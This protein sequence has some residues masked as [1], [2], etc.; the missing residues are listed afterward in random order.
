VTLFSNISVTS[1][2]KLLVEDLGLIFNMIKNL[3]IL[4][5]SIV[6]FEL[7]LRFSLLSGGQASA[8]YDEKI[9]YWHK[10]NFTSQ[11][12]RDCYNVEYKFGEYGEISPQQPYNDE[13]PNI[14]LLGNSYLEAA[15]V[16]NENIIHNSLYKKLNGKYNVL[17]FGLYGSNIFNQ[18]LI[19]QHKVPDYK[20]A[21]VM[22][23]VN[24]IQ[25]LDYKQKESSPLSRQLVEGSFEQGKTVAKITREF[26]TIE[27]IRDILGYTEFYEHALTSIATIKSLRTSKKPQES[28]TKTKTVEPLIIIKRNRSQKQWQQLKSGIRYMQTQALNK[29][30][31]YIAIV[32]S[33]NAF[34]KTNLVG[35]FINWLENEEIKYINLDEEITKYSIENYG[36]SCDFH[37]NDEVHQ[38]IGT[39]LANKMASF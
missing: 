30:S 5:T 11:H 39:I 14:T 13:L 9:G 4:L 34:K 22:Q 32:Y 25:A 17:N 27:L 18:A 38:T 24:F 21:Y 28:K 12:T 20:E 15:M 19:Y 37:W 7:T 36:F 16:E 31:E 29:G 1:S 2:S 10:S 33:G 6:V 23:F 8:V 26:N 3:L 35:D